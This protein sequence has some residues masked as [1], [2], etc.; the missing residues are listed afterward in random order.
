LGL[1]YFLGRLVAGLVTSLLTSI[2]FNRILAVIGLGLE[3]KEGQRTP[4]E[5]VGYV[6]LILVLLFAVIEASQLLG[7]GILAD[8]V[9]E[10]LV[11]AAQVILGIVILGLGLYLANLARGIIQRTTVAQAPL[12]SHA[13]WLAIVIL[14]AAMGLRTMGI[15]DD[16]INLA[17]GLLLGAIAVAVALAFGLG[18]RDI[19]ARQVESWLGQLKAGDDE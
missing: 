14:A 13:A 10:F 2:G 1:A 8:L 3:P 15:A 12:L 4:S 16:I 7:F 9:S 18:S 6:V 19:A 17:F 5:V 11:F